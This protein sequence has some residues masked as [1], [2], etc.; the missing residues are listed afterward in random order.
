MDTPRTREDL[1]VL[2]ANNT[3][4]QISAQKLRDFVASV[5]VTT[6]FDHTGIG[7]VTL[8]V[9]QSNTH[10]ILLQASV[11]LVLANASAGQVIT[12]IIQQD[13]IGG[14]A[15]S[16]WSGIKWQYGPPV[17]DLAPNAKT[18]IIFVTLSSGEYIQI[19]ASPRISWNE[20]PQGNVTGSNATFTLNAPPILSSLNLHKNGLLQAQGTENDFTLSG[21][22][23]SFNLGAIP[24]P[25][26]T[27]LANYAF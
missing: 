20:T 8:D 9:V 3:T 4:G 25:G 23:V 13:A 19:G 16:W 17:I 21:A 18:T 26:D 12:V 22:T 10:L 1:S 24:V 27:L 14:N 11:S 6:P 15:V 5:T 2:F 7:P